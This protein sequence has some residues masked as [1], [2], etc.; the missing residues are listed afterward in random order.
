MVKRFKTLF[1]H[2]RITGSIPVRVKIRLLHNKV[3]G[4]ILT[5]VK[6]IRIS[7]Q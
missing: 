3:T 2:N 6:I 4:S 5:G 7:S 1:L